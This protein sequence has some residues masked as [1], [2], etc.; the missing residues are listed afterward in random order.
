MLPPPPQSQNQAVPQM[1]IP[2]AGGVN[3]SGSA[4]PLPT[5]PVDPG[6]PMP[7]LR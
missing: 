2:F 3:G 6:A 4:A 5:Q 7:S 1:Q